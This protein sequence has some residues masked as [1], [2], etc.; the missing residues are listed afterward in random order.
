[1]TR[2][3]ILARMAAPAPG[4]ET[5]GGRAAGERWP[6]MQPVYR[7]PIITYTLIG[8]NVALWVAAA[9]LDPRGFLPGLWD[10]DLNALLQLGAKYGPAIQAGQYWR[11][12]TAM[13]LHGGVFHLA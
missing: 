8:V 9:A 6:L 10:P 12:V 3:P 13:F 4:S 7:R 1:M 11:L 5:E 2:R